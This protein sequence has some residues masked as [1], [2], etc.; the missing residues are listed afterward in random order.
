GITRVSLKMTRS[1]GSRRSGRSRTT[2]SSNSAGA[3]GRTTSRR[4]LSRGLAGRSAIASSGSSKSN[5]STRIAGSAGIPRGPGAPAPGDAGSTGGPGR[6][7]P[8]H[9][10]GRQERRRTKGW[11]PGRPALP[12]DAALLELGGDLQRD[13]AVGAAH[14]LAALD[15]VDVLPAL[16]E[17]APHGV[18]AVE[19]AGIV[20]ADEELAGGRVRVLGAGHGA[21]AAQMR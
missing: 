4:A 3:P 18:L 16:G 21:G 2:R 19:E 20:E 6:I 15:P 11:L 8:H 12:V 9:G 10:P 14:W 17:L 7:R 13:V 5:A 1:P